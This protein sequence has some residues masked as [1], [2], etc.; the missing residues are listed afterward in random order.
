V[1]GHFDHSLFFVMPMYPRPLTGCSGGGLLV[2]LLLADTRADT[3]RGNLPERRAMPDQEDRREWL[4]HDNG[5][6]SGPFLKT[7]VSA[8]MADNRVSQ[9]AQ[10][11]REGMPAWVGVMTIVPPPIGVSPQPNPVPTSAYCRNCGKPVD[12]R[13]IGCMSCGLAPSNGNRFCWNCGADTNPAA[14]VCIRC[15]VATQGGSRIN[16]AFGNAFSSEMVQPSN[17]PK[18]PALMCVLSVLIVGLGQI[19]LGQTA[20]GIVILVSAIAIS[21]LTCGYGLALAPV[22]W[23]ISGL[24]AYRIAEKL[25]QGKSVG[26]WE[27]F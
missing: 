18:D 4:I 6:R 8:M 27:F 3:L 16:T 20:K 14:V 9:S 19:I 1:R 11:W 21:V 15:G 22:F 2:A 5:Q 13:A 24:D 17:P 10:A 12:P 7:E 23:V 26:Q 25:K